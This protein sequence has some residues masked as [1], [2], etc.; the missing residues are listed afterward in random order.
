MNKRLLDLITETGKFSI[1]NLFLRLAQNE[2]IG[3]YLHNG[4]WADLGTIEKLKMAEDL[5]H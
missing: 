5:F 2:N 1:T 4:L 3:G